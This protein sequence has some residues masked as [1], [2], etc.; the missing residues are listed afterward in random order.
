LAFLDGGGFLAFLDARG[1]LG[2]G[3]WRRKEKMEV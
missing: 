2:E 3:G 1:F